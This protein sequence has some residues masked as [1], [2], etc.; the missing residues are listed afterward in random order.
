MGGRN[1]TL[2]TIACAECGAEFQKPAY[3]VSNNPK[4]YCSAD[5]V[6]VVRRRSAA[7]PEPLADRLWRYA[8]KGEPDECWNWTGFKYKGYGR[9]TQG[10]GSAKTTLQAH[11]VSWELVNG[12]LPAGMVACH[13]CDNPSCVNPDH[14]FAGTIADNNLDRDTKGRAAFG[15]RV[16]NSVLK[17]EQVVELLADLPTD[18]REIKAAARRYGVSDGAIA[19]IVRGDNWKHLRCP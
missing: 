13:R 3:V 18:R 12:P 5:C 6:R 11:R 10:K 8:K 19:A 7:S 2:V 17:E 14:I 15:E 16:G 1:R 4:R 9:I